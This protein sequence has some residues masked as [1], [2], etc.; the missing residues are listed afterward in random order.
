MKKMEKFSAYKLDNAAIKNVLGSGAKEDAQTSTS[1]T[2][3]VGNTTY[4]ETYDG[5][6][7]QLTWGYTT[8]P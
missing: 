6:T 1:R 3:T 8:N 4:T 5:Y 7:G 2:Y